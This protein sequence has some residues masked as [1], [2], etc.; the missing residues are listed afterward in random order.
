MQCVSLTC[1][2][3]MDENSL[4]RQFEVCLMAQ[5]LHSSLLEPECSKGWESSAVD[6]VELSLE[7]YQKMNKNIFPGTI[8]KDNIQPTNI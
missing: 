4:H 1:K 8:N 6:I 3:T 7:F 2:K 5:A